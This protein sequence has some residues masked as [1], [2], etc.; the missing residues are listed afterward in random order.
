MRAASTLLPVRKRFP[1]QNLH[2]S[3]RPSESLCSTPEKAEA[4]L[5][6]C[7]AKNRV[8]VLLPWLFIYLFD[9]CLPGAGRW[10]TFK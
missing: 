7:D 5:S 6:T 2:S 10:S 9:Q 8:A 1:F 4:F 3:L